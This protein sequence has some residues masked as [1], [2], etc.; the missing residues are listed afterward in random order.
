MVAGANKNI[1]C[2]SSDIAVTRVMAVLCISG[3]SSDSPDYR[4]VEKRV[5]ERMRNLEKQLQKLKTCMH[6]GIVSGDM[7][8]INVGIGEAYDPSSM[9]DAHM[10]VNIQ[11]RV[12]LSSLV[13][14][15]VGL[16]LRKIV[17]QKGEDVRYTLLKPPEVAL[18]DVL[19]NFVTPGDHDHVDKVQTPG[20]HDYVE[21]VQTSGDHG[22]ADIVRRLNSE[23]S[24]TATT[25]IDLFK[26]GAKADRGEIDDEWKFLDLCSE[27]AK[28]CIGEK[29][30]VYNCQVDGSLELREPVN[31][32]N[33]IPLQL[34]LQCVLVG[35][36]SGPVPGD[37]KALQWCYEMIRDRG[38]YL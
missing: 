7:E 20:G 17:M 3:L 35:W 36:F 9:I 1:E 11:T 28:G 12:P 4:N 15:T 19:E 31:P 24:N 8:L 26:R 33:W 10:E 25:I 29:L 30:Y 21:K 23:I 5:R 37:G 34:A 18:V 13:L 22:Y 14:C 27:V 32:K 6:E 2:S 16:G 38:K